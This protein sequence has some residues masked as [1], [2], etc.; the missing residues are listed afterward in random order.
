MDLHRRRCVVL[1]DAIG[2]GGEEEEEVTGSRT[3][4]TTRMS[5]AWRAGLT[6]GARG[7]TDAIMHVRKEFPE[8]KIEM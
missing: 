8:V 3:K 4:R 5:N 6:P 2:V 1:P 7:L